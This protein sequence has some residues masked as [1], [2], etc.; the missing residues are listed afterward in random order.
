MYSG[1]E[2]HKGAVHPWRMFQTILELVAKTFPVYAE[3]NVYSTVSKP[4]GHAMRAGS[5][6]EVLQVELETAVSV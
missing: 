3:K 1:G 4:Q 2:N 6:G 5:P